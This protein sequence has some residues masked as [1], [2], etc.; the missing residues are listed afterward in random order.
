MQTV[1][2]QASP[3][4]PDITEAAIRRIWRPQ[5]LLGLD[6]LPFPVFVWDLD[7]LQLRWAN[8][9]AV[10]FLGHPDLGT[11]LASTQADGLEESGRDRLL[12]WRH[13]LMRGERIQEGWMFTRRGQQVLMPCTATALVLDDTRREALLVAHA[14]AARSLGPYAGIDASELLRALPCPITV[15]R[16]DG[17][18]V[19]QNASA[20]TAYPQARRAL[21]ERF[22]VAA[23][24]SAVLHRCLEHGSAS[25][26]Y[27]MRTAAGQRV[28]RLTLRRLPV[29]IDGE[30]LALVLESDLG[31]Q[32]ALI[33]GLREALRQSSEMLR[34]R[35][36]FLLATSHALRTPL[37]AVSGFAQLMEAEP[38][39]GPHQRDQI[40]A[41]HEG[42][43]RIE[44]LANGIVAYVQSARTNG[45]VGTEPAE[46]LGTDGQGGL[47]VLE[48]LLVRGIPTRAFG[49]L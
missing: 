18:L 6:A 37:N 16:A 19:L 23:E 35:E 14:E 41:I 13:R 30:P 31:E 24:A 12:S 38:S 44:A 32:V 17:R 2:T 43:E 22:E 10:A 29:G 5:D 1:L 11:L 33:D 8:A 26:L 42:A 7:R 27:S 9:E 34:S 20:E 3:A 36:R 25:D 48:D 47:P 45:G 46:F 4:E 28:H 49:A 15:V 39:L 40:A 21:Q